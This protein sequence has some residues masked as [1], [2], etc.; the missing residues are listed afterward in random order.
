M[1]LKRLN[2]ANVA[3]GDTA[4]K[5]E[6]IYSI[7]KKPEHGAYRLEITPEK[8]AI[9]IEASIIG[10]IGSTQGYTLVLMAPQKLK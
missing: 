4:R 3:K 2:R 8:D 5:T 6:V 7:R 10:L 1:Y 9:D